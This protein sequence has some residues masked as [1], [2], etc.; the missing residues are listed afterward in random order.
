MHYEAFFFDFDGVL[1]D[2]VEVKT[3]AFAKLFEPHGPE[4]VE[5]VVDHHRRHGGMTR[6]DKFRHYY[7]EYLGTTLNDKEMA[8]L[9]RR[10]AALVVDEVVAA[11]EILGAEEFLRRWSSRVDCFVISA[12]PEEEIREIV[13]RRNMTGYFKG[14][15][16]ASV[17]KKTNLQNLLNKYGLNPLKCCFF[18]DAES[19]YQAARACGTHFIGIA[20]D[21]GAT[22]LQLHPGISWTKDFRD[23]EKILASKLT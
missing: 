18:G 19:D 1:A 17:D 8:D 23:L 5:R 12:T 21:A 4:N 9:C 14:V 10:F 16:G 11:P 13:R 22:L 3:R 15:F 7:R 2:S 6:V 20:P